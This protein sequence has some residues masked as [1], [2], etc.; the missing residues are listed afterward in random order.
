MRDRKKGKNRKKKANIN[1]STLVLFSLIHLVVLI[2]YKN[3]ALAQIKA[4]KPVTGNLVRE[5]EKWKNKGT[6][7]QY[8]ADS[9]IQSST[10]Q[11]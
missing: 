6:D 3:I 11:Y 8:K 2:V 9:L 7:K 4:E 5:K 10:C 1:L